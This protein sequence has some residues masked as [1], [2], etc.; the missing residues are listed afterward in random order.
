MKKFLILL[1]AM[2]MACTCLTGCFGPAIVV[3][4]DYEVNLDIPYDVEG[5]ITV[6]ISSVYTER[7][8]I[9][10]LI[11]EYN[12][13]YPNVEVTV[14]EVPPPY[15]NTLVR[16]WQSEP[17]EPGIMPDILLS[18]SLDMHVL[19][20]SGILLN[21]QKYIDESEAADLLDTGA[22]LPQ[23]WKMGQEGF[24][25]DQYL[26]PR[27]ADRVL[28]HINETRFNEVFAGYSED[29]L[30]FTPIPGTYVPANGW[31][32]QEF[33]D[34]CKIIRDWYDKN[35]RS[36]QFLLDSSFDWEAVYNPV[37]R[38]F[39]AELIGENGEVLIDT[40]E[41]EEAL[42]FMYDCIEKRYVAPMGGTV[43]AGFDVGQGCMIFSSAHAD[44]FY[45]E[46]NDQ[47]YEYN[48]TSFPLITG[49]LE[50]SYIGTGVGGYGMSSLSR[51]KDLAWTFLRFMLTADGQNALARGGMA[52]L[53]IRAD[54]SDP[55]TNVWG[56]ELEEAGINMEAYAYGTERCVVT[57]FFI[58]SGEPLVYADLQEAVG[59]LVNNCL[60][61][62]RNAIQGQMAS[63]QMIM[64]E[65]IAHPEV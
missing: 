18:N 51:N 17:Y 3:D 6:G 49:D 5:S 33:L 61:G 46:L 62:T 57:D 38:S 14:K 53:P 11:E 15:N 64:E 26:L 45:T 29:E 43:Q 60:S 42:N 13:V 34:T 2:I 54:M 36:E 35:D 21:L 10:A 19:I 59:T 1:A 7:G 9:N 48:V 31:T 20:E 55:S 28:T 4:D 41:V 27:S 16:Y 40:P 37:F 63:I 47:G 58:R 22:F 50:T 65:D 52:T 39:G 30:P 32:W 8:L 56:Q 25:G 24:D 44:R 12:Q 23:Y